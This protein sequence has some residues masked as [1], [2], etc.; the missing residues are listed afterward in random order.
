MSDLIFV[1]NKQFTEL[2]ARGI[3]EY[4]VNNLNVEMLLLNGFIIL[5]SNTKENE[6]DG[7]NIQ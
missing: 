3:G 2:K 7:D 5:I 6:A 4:L 1:S